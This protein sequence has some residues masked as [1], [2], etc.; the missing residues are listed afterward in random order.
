M[1]TGEPRTLEMSREEW[2][3][4]A[5]RYIRAAYDG[6]EMIPRDHP[7]YAWSPEA[8]SIGRELAAAVRQLLTARLAETDGRDAASLRE[9]RLVLG[10]YA[11]T[12]Q[13]DEAARVIRYS[14]DHELAEVES[15]GGT[16]AHRLW[17][18]AR[19]GDTSNRTLSRNGSPRR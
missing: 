18:T 9:R 12:G 3:A 17:T 4:D 13:W 7:V 8:A 10:R 1:Q 14:L 2:V 15:P 11:R 6:R 5:A 16:L 19:S